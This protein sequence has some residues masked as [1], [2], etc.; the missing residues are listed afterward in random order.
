[1]RVPRAARCRLRA[2]ALQSPDINADVATREV[3]LAVADVLGAAVRVALLLHV[4]A[5]G[6]VV[7]VEALLFPDPEV[8]GVRPGN[9]N[10]RSAPFSAAADPASACFP[11]RTEQWPAWGHAHVWRRQR[12]Q[13]NQKHPHPVNLDIAIPRV[14]GRAVHVSERSAL[15]CGQAHAPLMGLP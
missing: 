1:M 12:N 7:C 11:A 4:P 3:A 8:P 9:S 2:S 6:V 13:E 14:T 15:A 10:S 5:D